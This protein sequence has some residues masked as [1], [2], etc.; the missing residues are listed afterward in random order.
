MSMLTGRKAYLPLEESKAYKVVLTGWTERPNENPQEGSNIQGFLTFKWKVI[1][2]GRIV[3]DNRTFPVGT[4]IL[5]SALIQQLNSENAVEQE[6]LFQNILD[7]QTPVDMWVERKAKDDDTFTNYH[8][9]EFI[10]KVTPVN[11]A[12]STVEGFH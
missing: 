2:D 8:F 9:R 1:E 6:D 10:K 4:D 3:T 7:A 5:A 12:P 11:S